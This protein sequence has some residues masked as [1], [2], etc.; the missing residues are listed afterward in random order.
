LFADDDGC[1]VIDNF[2][3]AA[4]VVALVLLVSTRLGLVVSVHPMTIVVS[5]ETS[6]TGAMRPIRRIEFILSPC[7]NE[8]RRPDWRG[9]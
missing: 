2:F 1:E 3:A 4:L 6:A 5:T 8:V 7:I 9:S